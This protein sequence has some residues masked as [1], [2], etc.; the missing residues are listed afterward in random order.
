MK[1]LLSIFTVLIAAANF[2][3]ASGS[4]RASES[5]PELQTVPYVDVSRYLGAWYT[6]SRNPLIFEGKCVCSRQVLGVTSSGRVSVYN[7]CNEY[8]GGPLR[9]ISGFADNQDPKTNAKFIVDFN[10]PH[11]GSYWIIGLDK[12][13]RYA[14]VSDPSRMSLYILSKTP[15]LAPDLY[16]AAVAEVAGQIDVSKLEP[17]VQQGCTYP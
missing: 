2:A 15:D 13:Y 7:S 6:I 17:I 5:K 4:I 8:M 14:V 11:K 3:I 10:L 12:D 9:E 16:Q 1:S